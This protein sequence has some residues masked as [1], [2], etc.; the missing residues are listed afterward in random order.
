MPVEPFFVYGTPY[1]RE[2]R[3]F[4]ENMRNKV[5]SCDISWVII[6]DPNLLLKNSEKVRGKGVR[7]DLV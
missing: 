7:I 6:G 1:K 3:K 5:N 4:W 2:K